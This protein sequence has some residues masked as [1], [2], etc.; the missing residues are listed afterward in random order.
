MPNAGCRPKGRRLY[1]VKGRRARHSTC[2]GQPKA[3]ESFGVTLQQTGNPGLLLRGEGSSGC[4]TGTDR[5]N[6]SS[7]SS[8]GIR[9]DQ[10]LLDHGVRAQGVQDSPQ[11]RA[12][13]ERQKLV[14]VEQESPKKELPAT[15]SQLK[16]LS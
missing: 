5:A 6:P 11:Y 1:E 8:F 10:T 15:S 3:V 16:A 9:L 12:V 4:R 7:A 2:R 14:R 13:R